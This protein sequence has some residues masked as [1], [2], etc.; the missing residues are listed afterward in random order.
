[1]EELQRKRREA[2]ELKQLQQGDDDD[3]EDETDDEDDDYGPTPAAGVWA[4]SQKLQAESEAIANDE[5]DEGPM[6]KKQRTD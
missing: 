3:G 2:E 4:G 5:D 1:M 6:P